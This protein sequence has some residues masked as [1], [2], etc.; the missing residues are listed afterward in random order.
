MTI[1]PFS[2]CLKLYVDFRNVTQNLEK[3][4]LLQTKVYELGIANCHNIEQDTC[5]RQSMC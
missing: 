1:I 4:F 2:K 3:V 5:H